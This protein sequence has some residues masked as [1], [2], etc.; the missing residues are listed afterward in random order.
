MS[1]PEPAV[2]FGL[3]AEQELL[4][5]Q[6]RRFAEE[7]MAPGVRARDREHRFPSEL[8]AELGELGLF[9]VMVPE[10]Y[11]GAGF[12]AVATKPVSSVSSRGGRP[13]VLAKL[14][15]M[16][17]VRMRA[18]SSVAMAAFHG[19]PREVLCALKAEAIS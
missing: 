3:S 16:T 1:S 17:S 9:G 11:G 6:V 10:E 4:R 15:A 8:M 2:E 14:R 18:R 12:D 5:E 7:R 19:R 13:C